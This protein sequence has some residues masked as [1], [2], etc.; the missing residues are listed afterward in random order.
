LG[1]THPAGSLELEAVDLLGMLERPAGGILLVI[2]PA[3]VK[4]RLKG[5][6]LL[7]LLPR[8]LERLLGGL[9]LERAELDLELAFKVVA[10][11]G[12]QRVGISKLCSPGKTRRPATSSRSW[13]SVIPR[14]R[15][16]PRLT[17]PASNCMRRARRSRSEKRAS[18]SS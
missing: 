3:L 17:F 18:T 2:E 4:L 6:P 14:R 11:L 12:K 16:S 9:L 15:S 10:G 13:S 8:A 7:V 5:Q 1:V